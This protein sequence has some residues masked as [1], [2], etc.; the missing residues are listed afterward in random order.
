MKDT[1]NHYEKLM[2]IKYNKTRH[3]YKNSECGVYSVN[4][5]LRL[6]KGETFDHI[7]NNITTDDAVNECR[8]KYY[9]FE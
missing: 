5:I 1:N 3:Q 4:F 6:L 7:C 9:R 2:D 8:K